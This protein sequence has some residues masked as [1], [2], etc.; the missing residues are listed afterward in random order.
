MQRILI[1]DLPTRAFHALLAIGFLAA[2]SIALFARDSSPIFPFHALI[3]LVLALMVVL[4]IVWGVVG[5]RYARL[6]SFTP[7][8]GVVFAYF[9]DLVGHG[10]KRKLPATPGHN[11]GAAYGIFAMLGVVLGLAVTGYLMSRG[12][13]RFEEV[14]EVLAY[15]MV[16]L[17]LMHVAGVLVHLVRHRENIIASMIH[18]KKDGEPQDGIPSAEPIAGLIFLAIVVVWGFM[19]VRNYDADTRTTRLPLSSSIL[20]LGDAEEGEARAA[21]E[22][23]DLDED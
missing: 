23:L 12:D 20:E 21:T 16:G 8:P 14:H 22:S 9:E 3:G 18:G 5:T 4:R 11:A 17:V 7:R 10:S 1:W 2:A 6:S 13:E 15:T 19:L